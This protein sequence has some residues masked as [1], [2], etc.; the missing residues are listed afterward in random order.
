M[1]TVYLLQP[2][3]KAPVLQ[4][5]M[6]F[7]LS[8]SCQHSYLSQACSTMQNTYPP[9]CSSVWCS[10]CVSAVTKDNVHRVQTICTRPVQLACMGS[11]NCTGMSQMKKKFILGMRPAHPWG[12]TPLNK[13]KIMRGKDQIKMTSQGL[14]TVHH[15]LMTIRS[16]PIFQPLLSCT[17]ER[18]DTPLPLTPALN[19]LSS[20]QHSTVWSQQSYIPHLQ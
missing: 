1:L 2:S 8:L 20:I 17:C 18:L 5:G 16:P 7:V 13:E 14:H 10:N 19:T 4:F 3:Y 6:I 9:L 15:E 12:K 11:N